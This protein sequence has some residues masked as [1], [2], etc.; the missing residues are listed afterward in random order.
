MQRALLVLLVACNTHHSGTAAPDAPTV[1]CGVLDEAACNAE[2]A[3]YALYSPTTEAG[4]QTGG[5]YES[6]ANGPPTCAL[7]SGSNDGG[8]GFGGVGCPSGLALAFSVTDGDCTKGFTI[9][10]C[11]HT[12]A[13]P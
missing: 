1:A 3:C 11:V 6:C 4:P 5:M 7:R 2:P 13:C 10:G 12:N 9:T 8:C